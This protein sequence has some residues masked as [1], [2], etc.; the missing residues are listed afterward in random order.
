ME[1]REK[2]DRQKPRW[3][4]I[5][6]AGV[7]YTSLQKDTY[8]AVYRFSAVM[9]TPVNPEILQLALD[10]TIKRFPGFHMRMKKGLFWHYFEPDSRPGPFV[11]SDIANPCTP[12]RFQDKRSRLVR[13]YYYQSR[14]SIE[15]FHAVSDGAGALIFLRTL[16]AVYLRE[17]GIEIPDGEGILNVD[18]EPV[19]EEMEDAYVRYAT[20]KPLRDKMQKAAYPAGG[21]P[22]PFYTLN[23]IMGFLPLNQLREKARSY[24]VSVT[25][26]LTAILLQVLLERQKRERP[27]KLKPVALAIPINLRGWFPSKTLRNFILTMRPGIDPNLGEYTFPEIISQVHHYLRLNNNRQLM[28]ARL[29]ENVNFQRNRLLRIVPIFLKDPVVA[30]SYKLAGVRPYSTTYTNP[31]AFRVPPEMQEHIKHMEVILGQPYGNKVN[32]ASISYGNTMNITFASTIRE[33]DI[34]RDFFRFLVREG[35][36]VKVESNRKETLAPTQIW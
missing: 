17:Q 15:V 18:E 3:Y 1:A 19:P 35:I 30:L 16:L 4:K 29:T 6:N 10:R 33:T 7:L 26:Y 28:Q 14:I 31:G 9:T 25:E 22:E 27:Y 13:V 11:M 36:H 21:T 8:S 20:V 12:I 23:V 5:D 2:K 34:E 24:K 32:C